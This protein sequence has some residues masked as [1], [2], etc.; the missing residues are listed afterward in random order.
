M[1]YDPETYDTQLT[2]VEIDVLNDGLPGV[3][4]NMSKTGLQVV[5]FGNPNSMAIEVRCEDTDKQI[6]EGESRRGVWESGIYFK[7]SIAPYG[8]VLVTDFDQ[9]KMGLDFRST[10]FTEGA[11]DL[12]SEQVGTGIIYNNGNSGEIYGGKRWDGT[13]DPNDWLTLRMGTGGLRIVSQD[14][15]TEL[16]AIDN[17]GGV[18]LNGDI[19]WNGE[20]LENAENI[21]FTSSTG[22]SLSIATVILCGVV[23]LF[24]GYKQYCLSRKVKQLTVLVDTINKS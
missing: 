18:Y 10:L 6:A 1:S 22:S 13:D 2:G 3:Y 17:Y 9:A 24:M 11:I 8:R 4:P 20:R 7:N 14:N 12:R 23:I 5:G 19:Y 16:V 15:T 21:N